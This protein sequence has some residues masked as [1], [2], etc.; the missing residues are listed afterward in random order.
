MEINL[1]VLNQNGFTLLEILL[2][3]SI[4]TML[5]LFFISYMQKVNQQQT[6]LVATQEIN[7]LTTAAIQYRTIYSKWPSTIN[8]LAPFISSSNP[9]N[10]AACSP[11]KTTAGCTPYSIIT[12]STMS[13]FA[14]QVETPNVIIAQKLKESLPNAYTEGVSTIA[15]TTA[16]MASIK[17]PMP[18]G[19]LY[20]KGAV[21][22]DYTPSCSAYNSVD[23]SFNGI[24]DCAIFFNPSGSP[25]S[26]YGLL[27]I[28]N[29]ATPPN[30]KDKNLNQLSSYYQQYQPNSRHLSVANY[31]TAPTMFQFSM[32]NI[33]PLCPDNAVPTL[34]FIPTYSA[35]SGD[36]FSLRYAW[37]FKYIYPHL[38]TSPGSGWKSDTLTLCVNSMLSRVAGTFAG[39]TVNASMTVDG[40][41]D[42]VCIPEDSLTNWP[43][44][45]GTTGSMCP[46]SIGVPK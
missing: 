22:T 38:A 5:S 1:K 37:D 41:A 17:A 18:S 2:S 10:Q 6:V 21:P 12:S 16:S 35:S 14:I 31:S 13:Y 23:S 27:D 26:R 33:Y 44:H 19:I 28:A 4:L 40:I 15:F 8:N 30:G 39:D 20:A 11:W 46:S 42:V 29:Q 43:D 25:S 3:L 9:L 32:S 34:I 7:T 24:N 45:N 36:R